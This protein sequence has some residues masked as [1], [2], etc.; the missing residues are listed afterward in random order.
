MSASPARIAAGISAAGATIDP[1]A[2]A[3]LYA[4]LHEHEPYADVEVVR[5]LH[6]GD[7]PRRLASTFVARR[8]GLA[9]RPVLVFLH[10]GGYIAGERR[11][12]PDS[13]Y[14]DNVGL[15]AA[16]R[17]FIAVVATYRLAPAAPWP[18]VQED[19]AQLL[20]WAAE[21]ARAHG[22]GDPRSLFLMGHSAG[23]SHIAG[24]LGRPEFRARGPAVRGAILMSPTTGA[25]RDEDVLPDE[26]AFLDHERAY[27]GDDQTRYAEQ[28][29]LAGLAAAPVELLVIGPRLD[30]PFFVRRMERLREAFERAGRGDQFVR[31]DDHNHMSQLFALNTPDAA[32]GEAIFDFV[33][34]RLRPGTRWEM[35]A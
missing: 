21:L 30:P 28:D 20:S 32:P 29:C 23:A 5:D 4:G 11:V 34:A 2:T 25:T 7:H 22:D 24:Y 1:R 12:R 18:A 16:R 10:G 26:A 15:W 31:L 9:P 6:Y 27:F 17:G 3:S 35:P 13:P 8:E 14:Y 33:A 19:I